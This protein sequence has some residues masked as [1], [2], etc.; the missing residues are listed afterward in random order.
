MRVFQIGEHVRCWW[1]GKKAGEYYTP[2]PD[3]GD[4]VTIIIYD[5]D[6]VEDTAATAMTESAEAG[7]FYYDFASAGK[8]KGWWRIR[9]T[10]VDGTL[11][12]ISI[13]GF[14]LE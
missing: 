2:L 4:A 3:A 8:A 7:K 13:G 5:P 14:T 10:A 11:I 6:G 12:T 1:Y 9:C